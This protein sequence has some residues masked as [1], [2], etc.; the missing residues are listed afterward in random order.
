M[1]EG[2]R[3]CPRLAKKIAQAITPANALDVDWGEVD[4]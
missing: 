1:Y 4:T 3:N 2:S